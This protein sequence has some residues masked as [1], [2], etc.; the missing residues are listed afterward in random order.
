MYKHMFINA[1]L[2]GSTLLWP[3]CAHVH[4]HDPYQN[5]PAPLQ[6]EH[7][8]DLFHSVS[9]SCCTSGVLTNEN[10]TGEIRNINGS[11]A[12]EL[13]RSLVSE[14]S[15]TLIMKQLIHTCHIHRITKRTLQFS[16]SPISM[17]FRL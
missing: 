7:P 16:I 13:L 2:V 17:V 10:S 15:H 6:F 4:D 9:G 1:L 8:G 3:A 5:D 14:K 11:M 12:C